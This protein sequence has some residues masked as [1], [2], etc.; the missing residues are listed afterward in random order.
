MH[1]ALGVVAHI[2]NPVFNRLEQEGLEFKAS[3]GYI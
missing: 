1:G 3:M 2:C